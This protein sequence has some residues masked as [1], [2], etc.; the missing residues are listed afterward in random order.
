MKKILTINFLLVTFV[1]SYSQSSRFIWPIDCDKNEWTILYQPQDIIQDEINENNLFI[2]SSENCY[3]IAPESGTIVFAKYC[4]NSTLTRSMSFKPRIYESQDIKQTDQNIRD[5][6]VS[7]Y[8]KKSNR[9]IKP[10]FISYWITVKYEKGKTYNISGLRP[11]KYFS[12]GT[13]IKKGDTLGIVGY[14]YKKILQPS[15]S[16]SF[17]KNGISDDPMSPFGLKSTFKPDEVDNTDYSTHKHRE[18]EL[19]SD[20]RIF[21]ESLVMGHPGL[22]D[23]IDSTGMNKLFSHAESR[24]NSPMTSGTFF[25]VIKPIVDSIRDSHTSIKLN[26]KTCSIKD[27]KRQ[28]NIPIKFGL[29]RDSLIIFKAT[30]SLKSFIGKCIIKIDNVSKDSI[31]K[32]TNCLKRSNVG[33][34]IKSQDDYT[35]HRMF[36]VFYKMTFKKNFGNSISFVFSDGTKLKLKYQDF[37][38]YYNFLPEFKKDT[39]RSSSFSYRLENSETAYLDINTFSLLQ[40]EMREIQS[41]IKTISDSSVNNII[42]PV[43][44]KKW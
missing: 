24:I 23:F 32:R 35:K 15:I 6:I 44:M 7:D 27:R 20:F 29:Q 43:D 26:V 31:I 40:T 3:V 41:F 25:R 1:F 18:A 14:S 16:I 28:T 19:I 37:I 9:N 10:D 8:N 5:S 33:G 2:G 36:D 38:S 34:F 17:N 11:T 42:I 30:D 39:T 21:K 12:S 22:Y 13:E 4:Y